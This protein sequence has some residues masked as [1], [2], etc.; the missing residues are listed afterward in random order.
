MS[1]IYGTRQWLDVRTK[2][3]GEP[4]CEWPEY[5]SNGQTTC[6]TCLMYFSGNLLPHEKAR[7]DQHVEKQRRLIESIKARKTQPL[8]YY[9]P[10]PSRKVISSSAK[11]KLTKYIQEIEKDE[12]NRLQ[13]HKSKEIKE[14]KPKPVLEGEYCTYHH[15]RYGPHCHCNR[16]REGFIKWYSRY[17]R[18]KQCVKCDSMSCDCPRTSEGYIIKK[19]VVKEVY[20]KEGGKCEIHGKSNCDCGD[21][22]KCLVTE[23]LEGSII[24]KYCTLHHD[25]E[26]DCGKDRKFYKIIKQVPG[27]GHTYDKPGISGRV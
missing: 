25:A 24:R 2:E 11:T 8:T 10:S 16:D 23:T 1:I 21:S 15:A 7:H 20:E 6:K 13:L 9:R 17:D 19:I 4:W 12:G 5:N 3:T 18:K 27:E 26:C 22:V 14:I